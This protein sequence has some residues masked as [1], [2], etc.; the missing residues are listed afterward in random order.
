MFLHVDIN[1]YFAT[2][3]QQ[4]NPF[5]RNKPVGV[6]K[7]KGRT[8]IIA[9]SKEAKKFGVKTGC[10]LWE[11]KKL[12][13]KIITVPAEFNIYLDTTK[14]LKK[15]FENI[16]DD[17]EIFSLD[18]AF[19]PYDNCKFMYSSPFALAEKIQKEIKKEL[20]EVVTCNVGI[21]PNRL[22]AKIA[23]EIS[24]K[25]SVFEINE[26]NRVTILK[27]VE[28]KDVCGIGS[29]L[30]ERLLELGVRNPYDINNLSQEI[31]K[32][33][34]GEFLGDGIARIGKGEG[35]YILDG[36]DEKN[37][38]PHRSLPRT[39]IRGGDDSRGQ[40]GGVMK[41]VGRTITG[42]KL[43]DS[44]TEIK[45]IVY[46]LIDEVTY[47]VRKMNLAGRYV[48]I[49]LH[50]QEKTWHEHRT[51]KY[52]VRHTNEVFDILYN[53]LYKKFKR[54]FKVIRF[55]VS[56]G[57]LTR[58]ENVQP[59]LFLNWYKNEKLYKACDFIS[60]KYGLFTIH[61]AIL[62]EKDIIKPEVTGYLGDKKYQFME[63]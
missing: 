57:M 59:T 39:P 51:L 44:E 30:E 33:K 12:C 55:G 15:I 34:F 52:Y 56:L 4:E 62:N 31:L 20:G 21:G 26:G 40:G 45:R 1:S 6:V 5:L 60:E 25:G 23:S 61:S 32:E 17:A 3:L 43:C 24:P 50:G 18:E 53:Q 8:C 35:S 41:S 16:T 37:V 46:N 14:R 47:K 10:V 63:E 13:P 49:F 7:S 9:A 11:A 2:I 48:S 38:D 36:I 54:N 58:I 28:F 22:L 19:I 42:Y 27:T 29:R